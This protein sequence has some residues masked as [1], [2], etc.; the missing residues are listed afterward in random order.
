MV[1]RQWLSKEQ[2][3]IGTVSF[4]L[5]RL[6]MLNRNNSQQL[7]VWLVGMKILKRLLLLDGFGVTGHCAHQAGFH[8]PCLCSPEVLPQKQGP[9]IVSY[10]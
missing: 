1:I 4:S 8:S 6:Q 9:W 3:K 2:S 7:D 5:P 10:L